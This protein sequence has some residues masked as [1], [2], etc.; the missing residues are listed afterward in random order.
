MQLFVQTKIVIIASVLVGLVS[1]AVLIG[2]IGHGNVRHMAIFWPERVVQTVA[3]EDVDGKVQIQGIS[4]VGGDPNPYLATRVNFA[5]VL[6]V[7]NNG[8]KP[9]RL[10]IDGLDVQTDLIDPGKE[11]TLTIYPTEKGIYNYYDN[12]T[13]LIKLGTLEIHNV[14]PSDGFTGFLKDLI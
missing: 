3:F 7:Q 9:H 4:G 2:Y 12:S 5:Y 14:V 13:Q 8:D 1:F 10:Y 6:H 11:F